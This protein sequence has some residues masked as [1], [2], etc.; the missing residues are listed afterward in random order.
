MYKYRKE[1]QRRR[2][3]ELKEKTGKREKKDYYNYEVIEGGEE[4]SYFYQIT[5]QSLDSIF[6]DLAESAEIMLR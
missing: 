5:I 1:K 6:E 3:G 4:P 2:R